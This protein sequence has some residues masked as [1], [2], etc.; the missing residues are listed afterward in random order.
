M[1]D[2]KIILVLLFVIFVTTSAIIHV[3]DLLHSN[4]DCRL[5]ELGWEKLCVDITV[6][7]VQSVVLIYAIIGVPTTA[8]AGLVFKHLT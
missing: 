6:E 4:I 1:A 5:P 2:L 3:F 8:I 7:K